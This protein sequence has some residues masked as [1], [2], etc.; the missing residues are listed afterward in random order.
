MSTPLPP[1]PPQVAAPASTR[2]WYRKKRV[3]IPLAVLG[4]LVV[5]AII[6]DPEAGEESPAAAAAPAAVGKPDSP[7]E[8]PT[9]RAT[10]G[11]REEPLS[12]GTTAVVGDYEVAVVAFVGDATDEVRG[13]NLFNEAPGEGEIYSLARLRVTYRGDRQGFP[14]MELSV[15]YVGDDG[16]IYVDHDCGAVR[17]DSMMDQPQ[18]VAGGTAEGNFCLRMPAAVVGTGA[19]FVE[20]LFSFRDD[21]TWWAER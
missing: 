21:K 19:I 6:G 3:L 8:P 9:T 1:P 4:L 13:A 18:L 17:P 2:P 5:A 16:R 12:L 7:E 11:S 10:D 15:G 20:P 14:A